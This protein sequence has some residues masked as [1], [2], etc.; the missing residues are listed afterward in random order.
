MPQQNFATNI[1]GKNPLWNPD[2][3][4]KSRPP[5]SSTSFSPSLRRRQTHLYTMLPIGGRPKWADASGPRTDGNRSEYFDEV[6]RFGD[7]RELH[8][9]ATAA[10]ERFA[11]QSASLQ[12]AQLKGVM[13]AQVE[14]MSSYTQSRRRAGEASVKL[15]AEKSALVD[16]VTRLKPKDATDLRQHA[17]RHVDVTGWDTPWDTTLDSEPAFAPS[18]LKDTE[19]MVGVDDKLDYV[20][21]AFAH[22][23]F[24]VVAEIIAQ[25]QSHIDS[26]LAIVSEDFRVAVAAVKKTRHRIIEIRQLMTTIRNYR[27]KKR[28]DDVPPLVRS[29][30]ADN[31]MD[32]PSEWVA[33]DKLANTPAP[34]AAAAPKPVAKRERSASP[35]KTLLDTVSLKSMMTKLYYKAGEDVSATMADEDDDGTITNDEFGEWFRD[36]CE[37][38]ELEEPS[39]DDIN[40]EWDVLTGGGKETLTLEEFKDAIDVVQEEAK[41]STMTTKE[42]IMAKRAKKNRTSS[43]SS[44]SSS[45]LGLEGRMRGGGSN[46]S[47]SLDYFLLHHHTQTSQTSPTLR[48]SDP[49]TPPPPGAVVSQ[50][51]YVCSR[52]KW[53]SLS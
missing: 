42:K 17:E 48:P 32:V 52:Y 33:A 11:P 26:D 5:T 1:R 19:E 40:R 51:S 25:R 7:E 35:P 38:L 15:Y 28:H 8:A 2:E 12:D 37:S 50:K 9:A 13:M 43:A 21:K 27:Q 44:S 29:T 39:I 6:G 10:A 24:A 22:V 4:H 45:D 34:A 3:F 31:E 47:V 16:R 20:D 23:K 36:Y 53:I 46:D 30:L 14:Q 41:S 18:L 49:P